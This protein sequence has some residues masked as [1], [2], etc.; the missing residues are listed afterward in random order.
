L[1]S[2]VSRLPGSAA[3]MTRLDEALAAIALRP[4]PILQARVKRRRTPLAGVLLD[5]RNARHQSTR[6]NIS[7]GLAPQTLG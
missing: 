7:K 1:V 6:M 3:M 4:Q 5:Q 2:A